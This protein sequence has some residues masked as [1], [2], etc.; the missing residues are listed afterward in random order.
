MVLRC[1]NKK[2]PDQLI[3]VFKHFVSRNA[4]NIDG[5]GEKIL[6]QFIGEKLITKI[7]DLYSL[8]HEDISELPD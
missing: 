4:M 6:E 2:C 8:A 5:L 3:E 1:N 7:D